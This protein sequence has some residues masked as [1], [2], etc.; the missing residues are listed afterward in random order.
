MKRIRTMIVSKAWTV[1]AL[2]FFFSS[3]GMFLEDVG[4]EGEPCSTKDTCRG[5]LV[6]IDGICVLISTSDGDEASEQDDDDNDVTPPD[7]DE[8]N[9]SIITEDGDETDGDDDGVSDGDEPD[10]DMDSDGECECSTTNVCCDGCRWT[11]SACTPEDENAKGGHC[12]EGVCL[13]DTCQNGYDVS[14]DRLSCLE[15]SDGDSES[16][17]DGDDEV[18]EELADGN[19]EDMET[20]VSHASY[21]CHDGDVTWFDSC[22][23]P[24]EIKEEC[25]DC[26]CETNSCVLNTDYSHVCYNGDVHRFDCHGNRIT[27]I[28]ECSSCS[29]SGDTCMVESHTSYACYDGD[30]YW[31]DCQGN[32]E[33]KKEECG[34]FDCSAEAC[35][36]ATPGFVPIPA[37]SFWMGSPDGVTCPDGYPGDCT[38]ELG[39]EDD[40]TLHFVQLTY[41]FEMQRYE[42][43]QGEWQTAFGN[44]P[45]YFGPN[46]DGTDCGSDCPVERVNWNEA[47]AYANWLSQQQGLEPC[48]VLNDCA[49]TLGGGCSTNVIAC[50]SVTY[51][52]TVSLNNVSIPQECEGYRLPTEAE[53][54]YAA[55]AGSTTAFYPSDGNDG[56]ITVPTGG[57]DP[58][59]DQIGWY[60]YNSDV[61]SGQ[62]SHHTGELEA[63]IWGL[64]DMAGNVWE[65]AWDWYTT[66]YPSGSLMSPSVD[67]TGVA[68]SSGRV[69]RGGPWDGNVQLC[70]L[71]SRNGYTPSNRNVNIGFRLVRTLFG[72]CSPNPCPAHSTC[73]PA[74]ESCTCNNEHMTEDCSA[75]EEGYTGFPECVSCTIVESTTIMDFNTDLGSTG[76]PDES[77]WFDNNITFGPDDSFRYLHGGNTNMKVQDGHLVYERLGDDDADDAFVIYELPL[78]EE[79]ETYVK[80]DERTLDAKGF[81]SSSNLYYQEDGLPPNPISDNESNLQAVR[82]LIF[83]IDSYYA[84][85]ELVYS[86]TNG[87]WMHWNGSTWQSGTV[88]TVAFNG[89]SSSAEI[90]TQFRAFGDSI[91]IDVTVDDNPI[92]DSVSVLKEDLYGFAPR[93]VFFSWGS[94]DWWLSTGSVTTK[95]DEIQISHDSYCFQESSGCSDGTREG[96]SDVYLYPDI[97]SCAGEF[98]DRNLRATR[99][100]I[101]CGNTLEATCPTAEDLCAENWHICMRNGMVLDLGNRLDASECNSD[102]AGTGTFVVA[103][104]HC[105]STGPCQYI[106]PYNCYESSGCSEAIA[107]GIESPTDNGCDSGVWSGATHIAGVDGTTDY[108]C[109]NAPE[110]ITGVLCCK[111]PAL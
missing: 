27:K 20:C 62:T 104:S 55:R 67:P 31:Y 101:S 103:S 43:T 91:F 110:G 54:E 17:L 12:S 58:N 87:E 33:E 78:G 19:E 93:K 102:T 107:C 44:N 99:T 106:E 2:S 80:E 35:G 71:A 16:V 3:C 96:F 41:G 42:V 34:I 22:G 89:F 25:D 68:S 60:Y 11:A 1:F 4:H 82:I 13:I 52:C 53:W 28:E 49:G 109:G 69:E 77:N 84:K 29:C 64:Y 15:L 98:T 8:D 85:Y 100:N 94:Y 108:G 97:A 36:H 75:C 10:G 23:A 5:D 18:D 32:M 79:F 14:L 66:N 45:S 105:S 48:Y 70:R 83:R 88:E 47:L 76:E 74:D 51:N 50:D 81:Y 24:E 61:G 56:T 63:N 65:W 37:G 86:D 57:N 73:N 92:V 7:G 72:P 38:A 95:I 39:R 21:A 9:E 59:M 40:E 30:V 26:V 6:C 111:D 90:V 46:G